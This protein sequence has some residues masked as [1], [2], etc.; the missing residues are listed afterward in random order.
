MSKL[1][2]LSLN[3]FRNIFRERILYFMFIV[4][5]IVT[6]ITAKY[7]LPLLG[8]K[9]PVI[10]PYYPLIVMMLIFNVVGGIGF[11]V[12]SILLDERDEDVLTAIRI[13]PI[14]TNFFIAYRLLFAVTISFIFSLIM[15]LLSGIVEMPIVQAIISAFLLAIVTPIILLALAAF[16]SN[17]VEGLAIYKGLNLVLTIPVVSFFLPTT[18][19]PFFWIIPVFWSFQWFVEGA[20]GGPSWMVFWIALFSNLAAILGLVWVFRR[21][22]F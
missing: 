4:A 18:Y 5:P 13:T 7:V 21:R 11:V 10:E 12:A 15:I 14:S 16:S 8:A 17:K 19:Q 20:G 2:A 6:F 9:F 1:L 22:V 3:D